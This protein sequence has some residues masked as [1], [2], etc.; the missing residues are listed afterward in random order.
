[1]CRA[2]PLLLVEDEA[3]RSDR[4]EV[5]R[6]QLAKLLGVG[7]QFSG[8]SSAGKSG[9]RRPRRPPRR[10]YRPDAWGG[11]PG[12]TLRLRT[13]GLEEVGEDGSAAASAAPSRTASTTAASCSSNLLRTFRSS[14]RGEART[15][16]WKLQAAAI[17]HPNAPKRTSGSAGDAPG[18]MS[19]R[20]ASSARTAMTSPVTASGLG[21][22]PRS[23][24]GTA[25]PATSS[26]RKTTCAGPPVRNAR[27]C[28]ARTSAPS[29]RTAG[30]DNVH[31]N[32]P[33]RARVPAA[34]TPPTRAIVAP[35][36][37]TPS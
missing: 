6:E 23:R 34:S 11:L 7:V 5:R 22:S 31:S 32:S 15:P 18:Q 37:V 19:N 1:M 33:D 8:R 9:A 27:S 25:T 12:L 29:T 13:R 35:G 16:V 10:L 14:G 20:K 21:S 26:P 4:A 2:D 3:L 30:R 36:A 24:P 28:R 17:S